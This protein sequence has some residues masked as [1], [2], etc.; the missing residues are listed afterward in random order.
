[1]TTIKRLTARQEAYAVAL[2]SGVQPA[3]E[4]YERAGYSMRASRSTI[5]ANACRL[6]A[7]EAV[8][9]RVAALRAG[10]ASEVLW[11][12]TEAARVLKRT[13]ETADK[14]VQASGQPDDAGFIEADVPREAARTVLAAVDRLNTLFDVR[15]A[16]EDDDGVV[17]I[18]DI[19]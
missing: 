17:I 16:H 15:A 10:M 7:S 12:A 1:M 6:A 8:S 4:A 9:A 3:R 2:A 13:L 18:I 11:D 19:P 14:K 5:E